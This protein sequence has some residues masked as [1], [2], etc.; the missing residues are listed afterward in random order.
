MI[1]KKESELLNEF[2]RYKKENRMNEK[3]DVVQFE[4]W[5]KIAYPKIKMIHYSNTKIKIE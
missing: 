5:F 1:V 3:F 4:N 2:N